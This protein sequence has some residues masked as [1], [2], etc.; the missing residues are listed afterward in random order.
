MRSTL[1]KM[2]AMMLAF[3][4]V[5]TMASVLAV[6]AELKTGARTL[7][8]QE[9][10]TLGTSANYATLGTSMDGAFFADAIAVWGWNGITSYAPLSNQNGIDIFVGEGNFFDNSLDGG[11]SLDSIKNIY[12]DLNA[13]SNPTDSSKWAKYGTKTITIGFNAWTDDDGNLVWAKVPASGADG[14]K[15]LQFFTFQVDAGVA[16]IQLFD[17]DTIENIENGGDNGIW[18]VY[19]QECTKTYTET[20]GTATT[21]DDFVIR[22]QVLIG[23]GYVRNFDAETALWLDLFHGTHEYTKLFGYDFSLEGQKSYNTSGTNASVD[24]CLTAGS[25]DVTQ[26]DVVSSQYVTTTK[27][28][29]GTSFDINLLKE[30]LTTVS[31]PMLTDSIAAE[32]KGFFWGTD[33]SIYNAFAYMFFLNMR[34]NSLGFNANTADPRIGTSTLVPSDAKVY[35]EFG[36]LQGYLRLT[37]TTSNAVSGLQTTTA[38]GGELGGQV[39]TMWPVSD[40][41]DGRLVANQTQTLTASELEA[42]K[43]LLWEYMTYTSNYQPFGDSFS[44]PDN[45]NDYAAFIYETSRGTQSD[46]NFDTKIVALA[47]DMNLVDAGGKVDLQLV[48]TIGGADLVAG[49]SETDKAGKSLRDYGYTLNYYVDYTTDFMTQMTIDIHDKTLND[50]TTAYGTANFVV[51]I[52]KGAIVSAYSCTITQ[53]DETFVIPLQDGTFT[54][55]RIKVKTNYDDAVSPLADSDITDFNYSRLTFVEQIKLY[56]DRL[57]DANGTRVYNSNA[58]KVIYV[59]LINAIPGSG[60]AYF[61]SSGAFKADGY[62]GIKYYTKLTAL[63]SYVGFNKD[64]SKPVRNPVGYSKFYNTIDESV[65]LTAKQLW[66]TSF[67]LVYV[68]GTGDAVETITEVYYPLTPAQTLNYEAA[69]GNTYVYSVFFHTQYG[70]MPVAAAS[71][72]VAQK[73]DAKITSMGQ[74][75]YAIGTTGSDTGDG[76]SVGTVTKTET[77]GTITITNYWD[78]TRGMNNA[79]SGLSNYNKAITVL[80]VRIPAGATLSVSGT[81]TGVM[82]SVVGLEYGTLGLNSTDGLVDA[83]VTIEYSTVSSTSFTLTVNYDDGPNDGVKGV[84]A[85]SRSW[86]VTTNWVVRTD[87]NPDTTNAASKA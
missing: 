43:V 87:A 18:N 38:S 5:V 61:F 4:M 26:W 46:W 57:V 30:L 6:S 24:F 54:L 21:A 53:Y 42:G 64:G 11:F 60:D 45:Q 39:E 2:S 82:A 27:S 84:S 25:V 20:N 28:L 83:Y 86:T 33:T 75:S 50:I 15:M 22:G 16:Q 78:N 74:Y 72:G 48:P 77:K 63:L 36:N 56:N 80:A 34:Y 76:Y 14:S 35:Y 49:L 81:G 85:F 23:R 29:A 68:K 79:A 67:R 10:T 55:M 69:D 19:F 9:G 1:K 47:A 31:S 7:G 41:L 3:L 65:S 62:N 40:Y 66:D 12:I 37:W 59:D 58:N 70:D 52:A 13:W 44:Y 51:S 71:L 8:L 73:S 32:S 17:T